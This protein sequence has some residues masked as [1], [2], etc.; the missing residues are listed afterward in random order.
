[1]WDDTSPDWLPGGG[2]NCAGDR[3]IQNSHLFVVLVLCRVLDL[4]MKRPRHQRP[5]DPM[6]SVLYRLDAVVKMKP[7]DLMTNGYQNDRG[8]V[9]IIGLLTVIF[10]V[11]KVGHVVSWPWVVIL[12]PLWVSLMGFL[13]FAIFL[14]VTKA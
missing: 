13:V 9:G 11:L 12:A 5:F 10:L 2:R 4:S 6:D 3:A 7:E 1:M 14:W 8:G